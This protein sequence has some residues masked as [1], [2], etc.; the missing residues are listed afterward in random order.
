MTPPPKFTPKNNL[1]GLETQTLTRKKEETK[2]KVLEEIDEKKKKEL[3]DPSK[4][5]PGDGLANVLGP[6]AED[7]LEDN[8][9]NSK[10]LE[11][12]ALKNVNEEYGF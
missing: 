12:D 4:L 2:D 5:E 6:E 10:K 3:P 9:I 7:I 8:F 11:D 1:F